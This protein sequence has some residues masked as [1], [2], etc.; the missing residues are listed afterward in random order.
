VKKNETQLCRAAGLFK[1][2]NMNE[3]LFN[4]LREQGWRR[5]L[6]DAEEVEVRAYLAAHPEAQ[7]DWQ[8]EIGLNAALGKLPDAPVPSNFTARV[9]QAVERETAGASRGFAS[10]WS[11]HSLLPRAAVAAVVIGLGLISFQRYEAAK[12]AEM[13][14][15][16][17]AVADV[18]SLPSPAVLKDFDAIQLS[19]AAAADPEL[20][21]LMQ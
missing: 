21:K 5:K 11:W 4:Q 1:K 19:S 17:V 6:T 18:Q 15:S 7:P 8:T 2:G 14:R 10:N 9:L 13:V 3:S 20:I 16:I 12:R